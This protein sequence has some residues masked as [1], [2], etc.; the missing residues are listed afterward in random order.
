MGEEK[1]L[2]DLQECAFKLKF[3]PISTYRRAILGHKQFL[4]KTETENR[5]AL[6]KGGITLSFQIENALILNCIDITIMGYIITKRNEK[7]AV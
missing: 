4:K 7:P 6:D 5:K 3:I 1:C 2:T